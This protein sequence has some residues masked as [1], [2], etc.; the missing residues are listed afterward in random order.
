MLSLLLMTRRMTQS[1]CLGAQN[2]VD[3]FLP[4]WAKT[5]GGAPAPFRFWARDKM[6]PLETNARDKFISCQVESRELKSQGYKL[7]STMVAT[8]SLV[9]KIMVFSRFC[10]NSNLPPL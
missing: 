4:R 7:V 8:M 5:L 1:C 2:V 6:S 3:D 10:K 9:V